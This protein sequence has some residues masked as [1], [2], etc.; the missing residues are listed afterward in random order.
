MDG[1]EPGTPAENY[2]KKGYFSYPQSYRLAASGSIES[3]TMDMANG[4]MTSMTSAS[5]S[6]IIIFASGVWQGKDIKEAAKDGIMTA[7]Q[8][9]GKGAVIYTITMQLS[10]GKVW[11]YALGEGIKN[12]IGNASDKLAKKI[13]K[14]SIAESSVGEKL[15]L[16]K[17]TG[18]KLVSGT[19]T[20]AVVFGP[21]ICRACMGKISVKQLAKNATA[22]AAGIAGMAVGSAITGG[23][24]LGGMVGG[25]VGGAVGKKVMD[26]F[27]EDDAVAMFRVMKE[28]FLN[29]VMSSYLSQ[30][31]FEE[32]ARRTIWNKKVSKEL[33]NM[34]KKSKKGEHRAY[35]NSLIEEVVIDVLKNRKKITNEMWNEGQKLLGA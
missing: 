18:Q 6:A 26:N 29:V 33:Q 11:N 22:G 15:H 13:T 7:G 8:V 1:I 32:V 24:P 31:E 5:I 9:I 3:I 14:S 21:D 34:Y 20:V 17:M 10:R 4:I 28:E 19:V 30:E 12:P 23:N 25:A 16:N 35:A 27:I 2:L